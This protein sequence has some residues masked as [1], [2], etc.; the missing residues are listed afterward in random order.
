MS[1]IGMFS[2]SIPAYII[3]D[4]IFKFDSLGD[5]QKGSLNNF[6]QKSILK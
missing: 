2:H 1:E 5:E 3:H 4:D 6:G